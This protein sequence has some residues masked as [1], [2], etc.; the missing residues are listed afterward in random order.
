MLT[1]DF[2]MLLDTT[3]TFETPESIELSL[4]V[5]GLVPRISAWLIDFLIRLAIYIVSFIVLSMFGKFGM[6]MFLIVFFL[7]EW[8]YPVFFEVRSGAT[9]GKKKYNLLVCHDNGTPISWQSSIIRNLLRTADFLPIF[10]GA[11][12]LCMLF[13][14]DFKRLGDIAAGTI[15]VYDDLTTVYDVPDAQA[16]ALPTP[17]TLTHQKAI[18]EFAARLDTFSP[19]RQHELA[20]LLMPYVQSAN[21]ASDVG[22]RHVPDPVAQVVGYANFILQGAQATSQQSSQMNRFASSTQ[23]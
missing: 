8:F 3:R 23:R 4:N 11:G 7:I 17:I 1:K 21:L 9:P 22:Y 6:G 16:I 5:A 13:E 18:L 10:F 12:V 19:E 15:V 14:K 2:F 20:Q